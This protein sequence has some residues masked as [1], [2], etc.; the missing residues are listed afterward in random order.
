M[1]RL[2][3]RFKD[4]AWPGLKSYLWNILV[5]LDQMLNTLLSGCPDETFSARTH[6]KAEAGQWF[7]VALRRVI[8]QAFFWEDDHCRLSFENEKNRAQGPREYTNG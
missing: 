3:K 7:W 6:R 2:T 5:A 8:N 4:V 1:N